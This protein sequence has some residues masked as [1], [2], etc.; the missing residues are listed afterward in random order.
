M[1][2]FLPP[3]FDHVYHF[4]QILLGRIL[5]FERRTPTDFYPDLKMPPAS[6]LQNRYILVVTREQG[7]RNAHNAGNRLYSWDLITTSTIFDARHQWWEARVKMFE[8]WKNIDN[9][10]S[11]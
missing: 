1:D 11:M 9:I 5:N 2:D 7:N 3:K 6:I 10:K 4:I 8:C